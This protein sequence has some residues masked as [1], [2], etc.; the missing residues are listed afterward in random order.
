MR[1]TSSQSTVDA[2]N[3]SAAGEGYEA[4]MSMSSHDDEGMLKFV[5]FY[6]A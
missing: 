5:R 6:D 3:D 1:P 2:A 4:D